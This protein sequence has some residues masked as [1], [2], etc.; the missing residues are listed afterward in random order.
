MKW[1]SFLICSGSKV[2]NMTFSS[3]QE[4]TNK[5]LLYNVFSYCLSYM[6]FNT[7]KTMKTISVSDQIFLTGFVHTDSNPGDCKV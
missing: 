3:L 6:L 4:S 7:S 2:R 1:R 5:F